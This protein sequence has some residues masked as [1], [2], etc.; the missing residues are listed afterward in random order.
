MSNSRDELLAQRDEAEQA[1]A[2]AQMELDEIDRALHGGH[3]E[4]ADPATDPIF[5]L[6]AFQDGTYVF[7]WWPSLDEAKT[8]L[9]QSVHDI[10]TNEGLP[11]AEENRTD[12]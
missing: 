4:D 10:Q 2:R 3:A 6:T 5:Q 1:L 12:R 7:E 11:D 8:V 9:M